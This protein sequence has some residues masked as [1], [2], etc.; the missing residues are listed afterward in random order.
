M[1]IRDRHNVT[2][3]NIIVEDAQMGEGDAGS[4]NQLIEL[5]TAPSFWEG[6]GIGDYTRISDVT[7]ENIQVLSGKFPPSK[8]D[9]PN[10]KAIQN[11][12]FTNLVILGRRVTSASD[13]NFTIS[14]TTSN[15]TFQ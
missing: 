2:Y 1:C 6:T 7:F 13:G 11:V 8:I 15:I 9:A 10:G 5:S 3:S 12:S 14:G 4:N